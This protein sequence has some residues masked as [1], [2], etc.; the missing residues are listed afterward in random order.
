MTLVNRVIRRRVLL[1]VLLVTSLALLTGYYRESPAGPLH[2]VQTHAADVA[3]PFEQGAQRIA[4]PFRDLWGWSRGL[5]DAKDRADRLARENAALT[6]RLYAAAQAKQD[7]VDTQAIVRFTQDPLFQR[8]SVGWS[9]IGAHVTIRP[10]AVGS[11]VV[12]VDAGSNQGVRLYDP[13]VTGPGWLVGE[14]T[15]VGSSTSEV[16][17]LDDPGVRVGAILPQRN[18]EGEISASPG[19]PS[20]LQMQDVRTTKE[21]QP[22]DFVLT[23][24]F[25]TP[26]QHLRSHFPRGLPIGRVSSVSNTDTDLFKQIQVTPEADLT[27]FSTVLVLLPR[28][29]EA[30][31]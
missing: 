16:T 25:T 12:W 23:S 11:S 31:P 7:A 15:Q 17:L 27:S 2:A 20:T 5:I 21:V 1:G 3:L 29:P 18:A 9:T 24:G 8:I 14:V 19:D 4:Q 6:A 30:L 10:L 22:G 28:H 13:V 26:G